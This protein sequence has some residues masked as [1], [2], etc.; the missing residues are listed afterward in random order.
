MTATLQLNLSEALTAD[1]LAE[2]VDLAK[3]TGKSIERVLF[4]A[5]RDLADR[6]RAEGAQMALPMGKGGAL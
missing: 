2:V 6:A 4:E 3:R 5:A 1:E